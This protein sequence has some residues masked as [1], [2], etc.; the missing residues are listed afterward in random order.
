MNPTRIQVM[1]ITTGAIVYDGPMAGTAVTTNIITG[2]KTL[3][4]GG[5]RYRDTTNL[6][7]LFWP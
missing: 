7:I 2:R 3:H 6:L 4:L 1:E 5:R